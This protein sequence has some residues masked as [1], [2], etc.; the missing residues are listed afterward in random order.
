MYR[1]IVNKK[2]NYT[3]SNE[4]NAAFEFLDRN[5]F[6]SVTNYC[7]TFDFNDGTFENNREVFSWFAIMI[8]QLECIEANN[9]KKDFEEN[10][11][12]LLRWI[13]TIPLWY[14]SSVLHF[15]NRYAA[16]RNMDDEYT[17]FL[18]KEL[19]RAIE[20]ARVLVRDAVMKQLK[21]NGVE[22]NGTK[23]TVTLL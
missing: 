9:D 5:G 2:M 3:F 1:P 16:F 23:Y 18:D 17:R 12:D 10:R 19:L 8:R 7:K 6:E 20:E 15:V 14:R 22:I 21:E 13:K 11:C 4:L